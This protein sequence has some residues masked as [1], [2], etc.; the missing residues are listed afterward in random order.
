MDSF[1]YLLTIYSKSEK[2]NISDKELQQLIDGL[3]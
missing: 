3:D 2:E 1:V